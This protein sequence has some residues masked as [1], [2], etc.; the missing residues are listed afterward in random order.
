MPQK[1]VLSTIAIIAAV[2]SVGTASMV[3]T[4]VNVQALEGEGLAEIACNGF[5][6]LSG[7]E[8]VRPTESN[9]TGTGNFLY[10]KKSGEFSYWVNVNGLKKITG[11]H[12]HNGS[13]GQNG[14]VV[15][16]LSNE[17][18]AEDQN[19]PEILLKGN[20]TNDDLKGPLAGMKLSD[21]W[22]MME[23]GNT[24]INIH[25]DK[26][27]DGAIRGQ[28]ATHEGQMGEAMEKDDTSTDEGQMGETMEKD[29]AKS[30][31]EEP[32]DDET[33][34]DETSDEKS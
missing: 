6:S 28:L 3:L 24:Y 14:D 30:S 21:L 33:S 18:S 11:A 4:S 16:A 17:K 31:M 15:V 29:D 10:N 27:P 20:I 19:N 7:Q 32:S 5:S 22:I 8:E 9:A 13:P 25:T 23:G 12:I 34:D 26:Y 1:H 2:L